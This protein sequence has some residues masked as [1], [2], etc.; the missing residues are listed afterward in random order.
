M[1]SESKQAK[2][3]E[4]DEAS[5]QTERTSVNDEVNNIKVANACVRGRGYYN[6]VTHIR[7]VV[8]AR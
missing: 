8:V 1:G 6:F 5:K 3:N 7:W 2:K 4:A